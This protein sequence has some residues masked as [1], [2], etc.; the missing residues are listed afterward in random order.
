LRQ[1][2]VESG[3]RSA[4]SP[5]STAQ[6]APATAGLIL[7]LQ[8][9]AGNRALQPL[10]ARQR[11]APRNL[12]QRVVSPADEQTV[13]DHTR[14]GEFDAAIAFLDAQYQANNDLDYLRRGA[15]V[16]AESGDYARAAHWYKYLFLAHGYAS[17]AYQA[18]LAWRA[19]GDERKVDV[20]FRVVRRGKW[21]KA[22]GTPDESE[23]TA[24]T[25]ASAAELAE[26]KRILAR[27]DPGDVVVYPH[28]KSLEAHPHDF[29]TGKRFKREERGARAGEHTIAGEWAY[30]AVHG[31]P[32]AAPGAASGKKWDDLTPAEKDARATLYKERYG[33]PDL[34]IDAVRADIEKTA[35]SWKVTYAR[36]PDARAAMQ[37]HAG[38]TQGP[39]PAPV[40]FDTSA[41]YSISAGKGWAIFAMSAAGN[42]YATE[43]RVSRVHHT[44]PLAGGDV[45]GAGEISVS[46]GTMNGVT[47]KSGHYLPDKINLQQ[48]LTQFARLGVDL[49]NVHLEFHDAD[50]SRVWWE[51]KA[52]AFVTD[53]AN[54]AAFNTKKDRLLTARAIRRN[55]VAKSTT[56]DPN[57]WSA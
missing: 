8:Q 14:A 19:A 57:F 35:D 39:G 20:W 17:D 11:S 37:L 29:E 46:G 32:Q 24:T 22:V 5:R 31:N 51:G 4:E 33:F 7:S 43:H 3:A 55:A 54:D 38:L 45:A 53:V 40:P 27:L 52:A 16:V 10:L 50:G 1:H 36:T 9:T 18:A 34:R 28:V 30:N 13:V 12:V 23:K 21:S 6:G 2:A 49:A 41:M 48:S 25:P 26:A 15:R 56:D 42:V 47:N 44:S